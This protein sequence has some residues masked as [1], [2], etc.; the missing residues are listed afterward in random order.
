MKWLNSIY[1][2]VITITLVLLS[3]IGFAMNTHLE[4]ADTTK[5]S[6]SLETLNYEIPAELSNNLPIP[7]SKHTSFKT[8]ELWIHD[9][10]LDLES[11]TD[12]DGYSSRL[13]LLIDVD[14]IYPEQQIYIN[15]SL[16]DSIGI[17]SLLF[18][19]SPFFIYYDASSDALRVDSDLIEGYVADFYQIQ[20]DVHDARTGSLL[21]SHTLHQTPNS[22]SIQLESI[23]YDTD[24]YHYHDT[25]V[26]YHAVHS[27]SFTWIL[28]TL[29]IGCLIYR[30]KQ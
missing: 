22:R 15:I 14:S 12:L 29:A 2:S 26:S 10:W 25:V 30:H 18:T 4:T 6:D 11:D 23:E 5:K 8:D 7:T 17:G 20:I 3:N 19:S 1:H 24:S 27:G 21:L 28:L 13:S 16:I 9:I